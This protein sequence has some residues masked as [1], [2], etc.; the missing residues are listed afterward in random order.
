[1]KWLL[2]VAAIFSFACCTPPQKSV[3]P[4]PPPLALTV[5]CAHNL[6]HEVFFDEKQNFSVVHARHIDGSLVACGE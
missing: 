6:L 3:E 1:M 2:L 5:I 4:E